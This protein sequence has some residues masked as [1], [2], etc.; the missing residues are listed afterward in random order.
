MNKRLLVVGLLLV[1]LVLL[2][3][4]V[5]DGFQDAGAGGSDLKVIIAKAD[6]CG[7][8]KRAAPEFERLVNASPIRLADGRQAVVEMLDA[9]QQK[10]EVAALGVKGF[11]T[12]MIQKGGKN[13]EYPGERTYEGVVGFLEQA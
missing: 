7:H 2:R 11:P 4:S 6:W 13:I 8:C 1:L 5:V 9:D 10:S 12:I 3:Q